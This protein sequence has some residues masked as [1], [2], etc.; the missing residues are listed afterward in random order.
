MGL[1][2]IEEWQQ[3]NPSYWAQ[4]VLAQWRYAY[5]LANVEDP[6]FFGQVLVSASKVLEEGMERDGVIT[7]GVAQ[8]AEEVLAAISRT[9]KSYGLECVSHA[10]IDMN[11]M[12]GFHETVAITLETFRTMLDLMKEYPDFTFSQSQAS[13]Y[14]I[15]QEHDPELLDAIRTRVKEG[16]W[17]VSASTWVETDK[18][19]P[20]GESLARHILYT[21]QYLSGLLD[22]DAKSL[23]LDFEPDTFGHSRNVP[24]VLV[25]G[26]VRWYYH[27][28]GYDGHTIYRWQA[29]SGE[30]VLVYREP[31]WYNSEIRWDMGCQVP[32]F[33]AS[34]GIR[35]MLKVYGV[36]DHGGGPTRRDLERIRD[37]ASWPVYPT[38]TFGTYRQYFEYLEQ[39]AVEFPVVDHE[40]NSVFTGCYT[41]Q[42]RIKAGNY[43]AQNG[44]YEAELLQVITQLETGQT[45][46]GASLFRE[47][48]EKILFN[49]FH[50]ILPGSGTAET[51]EHAM[52][53]YQEALAV[54]QTQVLKGLRAVSDRVWEFTDGD[55]SQQ[56]TAEGAGVGFGGAAGISQTA[57]SAGDIRSFAVF[58]AT[59]YACSGPA[60]IVVW[61]WPHGP[62]E[63]CF[64]LSDGTALQHQ[65][66][67]SGTHQYWGHT[68]VSVLLNV[69]VPATGFAAVTLRR[70]ERTQQRLERPR[71]PRV[72]RPRLLVLENDKIRAVFSH[73]GVLTSLVAKGTNEELVDAHR[74]GGMF[75]FVMEDDS[76]GMTSWRVGDYR[77]IQP[78][79]A[80][81]RLEQL[82]LGADNVRQSLSFAWTLGGSK[83]RAAISLDAQSTSLH[84]DVKVDWY[85][86]GRQ[87][88]GIPQLQFYCPLA[89][90][91]MAY[92]Y[93]VPF[94]AV[95]RE[96][97][98][99]DVPA[100]SWAWALPGRSGPSAALLGHG[101]HGF[102]GHADAL[103]LTLLRSSYDPDPA[104][105]FGRHT[106]AFDL[107]VFSGPTAQGT[108]MQWAKTK[109]LPL[110]TTSLKRVAASGDTR[111]CLI[112]AMQ[113][114][115]MLS[116]VKL[117]EDA[118]SAALILRVYETEGKRGQGTITLAFPPAGVQLVN[119]SEQ[120]LNDQTG[121]FWDG[122]QSEFTVSLKPHEVVS[123]QIQSWA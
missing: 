83:V 13:V 66:V 33:C 27:C 65:V 14:R 103:S 100:N 88:V 92:T 15:V 45:Y 43:A 77:Q 40:L 8:Q 34:N 75:R 111:S 105:E 56:T 42:S 72:D 90:P 12:W 25:K 46:A 117:A 36:G 73:Q 123:I 4:R 35:R 78:L 7:D 86:Q 121:L 109:R 21:K 22:I 70:P 37:M 47:P 97:A 94:G 10:H 63:M 68:F 31:L 101:K 115:M 76:Q 107:G 96:S 53:L 39:T 116:G 5:E 98:D 44:L 24:E 20:M 85:E 84:Y 49:H 9:A 67:D 19:I 50:D 93:D 60:E 18:N 89:Y 104:P 41:S 71:D 119:L 52:G 95:T 1:E 113:G 17:E 106:M 81:G 102:R 61:D 69:T 108:V 26:G 28:R 74:L 57:R 62:D 110:L 16:R 23:A 38:I 80:D 3:N 114:P 122:S 51:R 29:P 30:T 79:N 2:R 11:W 64:A 55:G 99:M 118:G 120:P 58:N 32:S 6:E 112:Q 82:S 54:S 48:W 59:E 91:V 87:A